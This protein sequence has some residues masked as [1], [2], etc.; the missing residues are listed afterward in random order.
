[1]LKNIFKNLGLI[2]S[3]F[4]LVIL[5]TSVAS[6]VGFGGFVTCDG[7]TCNLCNLV[8]M[9]DLII[10]WLFLVIF[11]IFAVIMFIAGWGLVTSGGNSSALNDAKTKF[12]NAL[13]GLLIVMAAWL[14]IDTIMKGLVGGGSVVD[15]DGNPVNSGEIAGWGPWSQVQCQTQ[16]EAKEFVREGTDAIDDAQGLVKPPTGTGSDTHKE[17]LA[18]LAGHNI[19]L[20]SSGNCSDASNPKCTSLDGIKKSTLQGV[21]DLQEAARTPLVMTGGTEAG[22]ASGPYSHAN[23][24][25]VDIRPNTKLNNYITSNFTKIGPTKYQDSKGNTYYRHDPDHWDITITN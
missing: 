10:D 8:Q 2:M 21:I 11:L 24:Y 14:L 25:K 13:I 6:A 18:E 23:G 4:V 7:A 9:I 20:V 5:P 22:H 16:I 1:M 17:A 15:K 3:V 12:Q 19:T